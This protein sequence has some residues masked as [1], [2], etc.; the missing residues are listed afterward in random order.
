MENPLYAKIFR[1]VSWALLL[2]SAGLTVWAFTRFNVGQDAEASAVEVMLDWTYVMIVIA[3]IA[4]VVIGVFITAKTSPK[5]L[6]SLCIV[7]AGAVVLC[8][9]AYL[10]APGTPAIGFNGTTPP[11]T[12][13]LKLTDTV[14]NLAYI[15]CGATIVAI[16][17][18]ECWSYIRSKKA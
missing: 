3:L 5:S 2:I 11:T 1:W 18:G 17:V 7:L 16:I 14:L 15:L 6:V 10:L 4:V 8:L 12:A 13:E 9:V